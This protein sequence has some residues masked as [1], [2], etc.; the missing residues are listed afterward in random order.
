MANGKK[1]TVGNHQLPITNYQ[2]AFSIFICV[3]IRFH[4]ETLTCWKVSGKSRLYLGE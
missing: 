1:L 4:M 2:L 3:H